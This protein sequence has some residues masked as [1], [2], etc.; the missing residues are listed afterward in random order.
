MI[1]TLDMKKVA[2]IGIGTSAI[3]TALSCMKSGFNITFFY[4]PEVK[5]LSVGESTT[6]HIANLLSDTLKIT[7]HDLVEQGIASYKMG[8]NFIG[9]GNSQQFYHNFGSMN[10]G[11]HFDSGVFNEYIH[12]HIEKTNRAS[13]VARRVENEYELFNDYDFVI[14]CTGWDDSCEHIE[15]VFNSVNSAAI[16]QKELN[17]DRYFDSLH[18]FHR[19]T[20]DGWQF[21]IPHPE[22]GISRCG[23]LFNSDL[24]SADEVKS[25]LTAEITKVFSW[26]Q[27]YA[28]E[29][30][31]KHNIAFNGNRLFFLEPLQ[32]LSLHLT[33][34]F[35]SLIC[36][37]ISDPSESKRLIINS[38][39]LTEMWI[40]QILLAYHYQHGSRYDT[41]FWNKT[42]ANAKDLMKYQLNG[43]DEVF[44]YNLQI[45]QYLP[46]EHRSAI[47]LLS[48]EDHIQLQRGLRPES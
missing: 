12:N 11:I 1:K 5:P 27:K 35:A 36:D 24:I 26:K 47:G 16:F 7:I 3:L 48:H 29:I 14:N 13:Y 17:V 10:Y 45:D 43:V 42:S 15:P 19:A 33:V 20:E 4:D 30:I 44:K 9:W 32:A 37:Y 38:K 6:P 39:Y 23:Y 2:I 41:E 40:H 31:P 21:E 8:V 46:Q 34:F 22:K 18:T 28:K 25:K